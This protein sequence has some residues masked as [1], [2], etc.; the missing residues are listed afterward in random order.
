MMG[1]IS[2]RRIWRSGD[3]CGRV[4]ALPRRGVLL[5]A[6]EASEHIDLILRRPDREGFAPHFHP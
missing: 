3:D 1:E 4:S 2:N 6:P 5:G